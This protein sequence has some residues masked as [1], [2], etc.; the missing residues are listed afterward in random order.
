MKS[1]KF[2]VYHDMDLSKIP[3]LNNGLYGDL[4]V[5]KTLDYMTRRYIQPLAKRFD[6]SKMTLADS[7]AGFGWLSFAYLLAGGGKAIL[8]EPD[9]ERLEAAKELAKILG[10]ENRCEFIQA[11]LQDAPF[12]ENSVDIFASV[13]TL[14]HVGRKNISA[15]VEKISHSARQAV[16]LTSPNG[17]FPIVAHDTRLP[18]AHWLPTT[19]RAPYADFFGRSESNHNNDFL[20]ASDIDSLYEKFSPST[21]FLT[22]STYQEF[23]DYYPHYLP[24]GPASHRQRLAP[25]FLLRNFV[26]FTGHLFGTHSYRVSPNFSSIWLRK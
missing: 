19:I 22:F 15:C 16:L 25:S 24:Y 10:I 6:L 13:E 14:E 5:P 4:D 9:G 2:D 3:Y 8:V 17:L 23:L 12:E 7:A 26:R 11:L 21:S 1:N 18:F 20:V